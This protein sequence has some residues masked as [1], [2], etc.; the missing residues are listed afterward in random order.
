M[1]LTRIC[2]ILLILLLLC[3]FSACEKI[4]LSDGKPSDSPDAPSAE[5][6]SELVVK[7]TLVGNDAFRPAG[8][9]NP[10]AERILNQISA[11][12]KATGYKVTVETVSQETLSTAFA[13]A[14]RSGSFYADVIQT[15]AMFLTSY[16]TEGNLLSL[17]QAGL[18]ESE[19][20]VL[21]SPD[22]T[23]YALRA[24][25]WNNPLPTL[26][27]LMYYNEKILTDSGCET[28]LELQEA[29][30]WN[31]EQFEKLC[32]KVTAANQKEIYAIAEPTREE[33]T[34]IWA[35][36]HSANAKYFNED[37]TCVMDSPEAL[38]G[39]GALKSLLASGVTYSLNSEINHTA[40][41]TAKLAFTN[42]RTAFLVENS[43]LLFESDETSLSQ[44]LQEDLRIIGFPTLNP[45]AEQTA[46]TQQD[47]FCSVTDGA[48]LTLCQTL[49]P[50]LF[51]PT[52]EVD[53]KGEVIDEQFYHSEDGALYFRLLSSADTDTS[54]L[55]GEH[56]SLV[57]DF[58]VQ[59]AKGGS[60]KEILSNLQT[61]FN[62]SRKG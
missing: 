33:P 11:A 12:E 62:E 27:Y 52:E 53:A 1:K 18:E 17:A 24:D 30:V 38:A 34:L 39:F 50:L 46:F 4:D 26:S 13:R 15:D 58:F 35:T 48:D 44:N 51:A 5:K 10:T 6:R 61:I 45:N 56:R 20:G 36:L 2:S 25:G 42:R 43:K 47:V 60:A 31:W 14:C 28:P 23:A 41:P 7:T 22:G 19:T 29:G 54:L 40:D 37:G 57:E 8:S 9:S 21:R 59:V 32:K 55:M 49:I 16:Y 3:S